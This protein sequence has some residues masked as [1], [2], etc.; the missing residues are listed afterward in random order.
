MCYFVK[1]TMG[2]FGVTLTGSLV[3]L[4]GAAWA[5]A[6]FARQAFVFRQMY[7]DDDE[8]RDDEK[9]RR[10]AE[11]FIKAKVPEARFSFSFGKNDYQHFTDQGWIYTVEVCET[12]L[13][14]LL[15]GSRQVRVKAY[16]T[17]FARW[18]S[19]TRV[20]F[21]EEQLTECYKLQ[22][23]IADREQILRNFLNK[24]KS[25]NAS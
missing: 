5:N 6:K 16:T 17:L 11:T 12:T 3:A 1:V 9:V 20:E 15:N 23:D 14:D 13:A 7:D 24:W 21:T 19:P 4:C 18:S 10:A 22:E 2:W 8:L 25:A